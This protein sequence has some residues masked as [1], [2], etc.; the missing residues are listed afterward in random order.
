[1]TYFDFLMGESHFLLFFECSSIS[2]LDFLRGWNVSFLRQSLLEWALVGTNQRRHKWL[3]FQPAK[4]QK[5]KILFIFDSN[6]NNFTFSRMAQKAC[7]QSKTFTRQKFDKYK[8][9][10]VALA[11]KTTIQRLF[12]F[13]KHNKLSISIFVY[14]SY[15]SQAPRRREYLL[16][17]DF[18][19]VL[20]A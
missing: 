7:W 20:R 18:K 2:S 12:T 17:S 5:S 3:I 19:I 14:L 9:F 1:M 8:K 6:T 13:T 4:R 10:W 16:F 15:L 11:N